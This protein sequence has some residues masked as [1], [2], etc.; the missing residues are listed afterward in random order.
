LD[1][2]FGN[3]GY[4]GGGGREGKT[5]PMWGRGENYIHIRAPKS[6]ESQRWKNNSSYNV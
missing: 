2:E 3:G 5:H 1:E 4:L 6:T